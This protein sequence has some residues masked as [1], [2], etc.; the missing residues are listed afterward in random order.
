M[1]KLAEVIAKLAMKTAVSA[2]GTASQWLVY[3]P[4]EP[5]MLKKLRK[6]IGKTGYGNTVPC[7][8]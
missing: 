8:Y 7:L 6:Y 2:G 3:Q 1:K 4:A 5:A